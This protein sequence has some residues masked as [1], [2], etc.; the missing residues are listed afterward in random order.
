MVEKSRSQESPAPEWA[1]T[2]LGV[3]YERPV[4]ITRSSGGG[5]SRHK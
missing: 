3:R 1:D 2:H 5:G 4:T